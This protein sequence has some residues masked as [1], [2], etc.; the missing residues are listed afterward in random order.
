MISLS[1]NL[2]KVTAP[3]TFSKAE[4]VSS[5]GTQRLRCEF[6]APPINSVLCCDNNLKTSTT[7]HKS[8]S[9]RVLRA[10]ATLCLPL[11]VRQLISILPSSTLRVLLSRSIFGIL[12]SAMST[13][14]ALPVLSNIS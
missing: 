10:A 6:D 14:I 8:V 4:A 2:H 13:E 7:H 11:S 3:P 12:T 9:E 5:C 1:I